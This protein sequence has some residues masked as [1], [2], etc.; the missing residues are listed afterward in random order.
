MCACKACALQGHKYIYFSICTE[1]VCVC[2]CV[3]VCAV[4]LQDLAGIEVQIFT[5]WEIYLLEFVC[6]C[7]CVCVQGQSAAGGGLIE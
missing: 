1:H 2:V 6:V 5:P 3:C 7:V 4:M